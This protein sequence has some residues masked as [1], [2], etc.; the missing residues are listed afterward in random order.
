M[1][2]INFI[3]SLSFASNVSSWAASAVRC[4][5]V[6]ALRFN[7]KEKSSS[8]RK[9]NRIASTG[10]IGKLRTRAN[11]PV[12]VGESNPIITPIPNDI[13]CGRRS[14]PYYVSTEYYSE[15]NIYIINNTSS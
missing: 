6:E 9:Q 14:L 8:P 15:I 1:L 2:M 5:F 7:A 10:K 4:R 3:V 11:E 12:V 13:P